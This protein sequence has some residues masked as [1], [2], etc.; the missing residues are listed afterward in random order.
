LNFV[1][2][3]SSAHTIVKIVSQWLK[4]ILQ[5]IRYEVCKLAIRVITSVRGAE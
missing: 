2:V 1:I 3:Y 5:R 4:Y